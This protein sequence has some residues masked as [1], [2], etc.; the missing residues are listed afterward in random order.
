AA[1]ER[2]FAQAKKSDSAAAKR[3]S[4]P[5]LT[6]PLAETASWQSREVRQGGLLRRQK[7]KLSSAASPLGR[8]TSSLLLH[9]RSNQE[10]SRPGR[11]PVGCADRSP[12]LLA[13]SVAAHQARFAQTCGPLKPPSPLRCSVRSNGEGARATEKAKA[14]ADSTPQPGGFR[15]DKKTG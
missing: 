4:K 6:F 1:E 13:A 2:F 9:R 14:K 11:E 12:A 8:V 3:M 7:Q 5:L 15:D 10:E